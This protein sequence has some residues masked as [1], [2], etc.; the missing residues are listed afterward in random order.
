MPVE[1]CVYTDLLVLL[2]FQPCVWL[3]LVILIMVTFFKARVPVS[4]FGAWNQSETDQK[5]KGK[6]KS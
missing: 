6:V 2:A 3:P 4:K 5:I 1:K